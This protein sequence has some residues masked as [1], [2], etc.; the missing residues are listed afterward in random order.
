MR[1]KIAS[2]TKPPQRFQD[3]GGAV[4]LRDGGGEGGNDESRELK[5][6]LLHVVEGMLQ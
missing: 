2:S 3:V 5:N 6:E 4:G 1:L